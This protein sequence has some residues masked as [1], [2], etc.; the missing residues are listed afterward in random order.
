MTQKRKTASDKK[1]VHQPPV[2]N[3]AA[4]GFCL[5]GHHLATY[6]CAADL[7]GLTYK[8]VAMKAGNTAHLRKFKSGGLAYLSRSQ[9]KEHIRLGFRS[10]DG[11][12]N[13]DCEKVFEQESQPESEGS[14]LQIPPPLRGSAAAQSV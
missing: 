7:L 1:A 11:K 3:T 10:D 12:C 5:A 8:T 9:I 14:P 2:H 13:G 4:C 6:G